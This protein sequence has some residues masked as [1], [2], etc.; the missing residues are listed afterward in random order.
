MPSAALATGCAD[1]VMPTSITR[2][3]TISM[4]CIQQTCTGQEAKWC[5][6]PAAE[7]IASVPNPSSSPMM[8][9]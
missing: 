1:L 2:N 5:H 3:L 6:A 9:P 8:R 7:T 4:S